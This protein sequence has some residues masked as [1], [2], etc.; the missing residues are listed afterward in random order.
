MRGPAVASGSATKRKH[1]KTQQREN[2]QKHNKEKTFKN[3][4]KR[5]HSKT[6]QKWK[7]I[8]TQ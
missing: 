3:T 8:Y 6:Q 5:K 4:T 1:S 2:I 7:P